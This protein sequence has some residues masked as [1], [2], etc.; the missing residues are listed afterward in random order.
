MTTKS[1]Q[2]LHWMPRALA[3][4]YALFIGLFALDVWDMDGTLL[5]RIGAFLIHLLPTFVVLAA[6]AVAWKRPTIGGV[7]FLLLAGVYT[8]FFNWA[9]D[10]RNL[11]VLALPLAITGVLFLWDGR[12]SLGRLQPHF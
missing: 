7:L 5:A 4:A 6:L 12:V 10:W 2:I 9:M 11:L 8:L 1:S 3:A